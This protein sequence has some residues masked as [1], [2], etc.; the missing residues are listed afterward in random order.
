MMLLRPYQRAFVNAVFQSWQ[1]FNRTLGV[2]PT[3]S[4]KMII[5][6]EICRHRLKHG[7]ILVLAHRDELI[8]QA[9]DKLYRA[10]G[11]G[12][13]KE[14]AADYADLDAGIVVA[15]V[16]TL[17]RQ[18]RRERYRRGHFTTAVIDESHH[19]PAPS[20]QGIL[21]YFEL[22]KILGVTAT[23]DRGD[24]RA[25]GTFFE[26]I[27]YEISLVQLIKDGYLSPIKVRTVPVSIDIT[28]VSARAGDFS[29]EELAVA[30]EPVLEEVAEG[31][32]TYAKERKAL[33]FV[34]LV[35]IADQ[36]AEILRSHG[37]AAEMISGK[38]ADRREK[39]ARFGSRETRVLV[40]ASLLTEGFDEPSIDCVVCLRPTKI[41][42]FYAQM[43][44]RGTRICPGKQ[45][46][47]LL[48]FL[49]ISRQHSLVKP[50]SLIAHNEHE[51]AGIEACLD[52]SEGDLVGAQNTSR[53]RD[54]ARQI[55]LQRKLNG[56]VHDLL[57]LIDIC[58]AYH[59]PEL[60]HYAP[61][62]HW[63][64]RDITAKQ[65]DFLRRCR[66]DLSGV[67]DRGHAA[68]IITAIIAHNE[69]LPATLKQ[70]NYL[71]YLGYRGETQG[72]SKSAAGRLISQF[73]AQV[74]T[75]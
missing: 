3:G 43:V 6:A 73:K 10:R 8:D 27:A 15:S 9:R 55:L 5:F 68:T 31:I 54:L 60:E 29:E 49:W 66:V 16:Q 32:A 19:V 1:Q 59:A 39:L 75:A 40:N 21:S 34:P 46:L 7:R 52:E 41:R 42:S 38:C 65:T 67:R 45:N 48:D 22:D 33:V 44:G 12:S 13:A 63:H 53:E 4:G 74:A 30:L 24:A 47:L 35:R 50:A 20:Y 56:E 37:F 17:A 62:M 57:D 51:A 61:T 11:L 71:R 58:V 25:L 64:T 18:K 2:A 70:S 69:K 23:P 28:G 26:D 72:L 36:F 14:K